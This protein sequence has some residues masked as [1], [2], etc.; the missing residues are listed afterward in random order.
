MY[1]AECWRKPGEREC[2]VALSWSKERQRA[3]MQRRGTEE[4]NPQGETRPEFF[5]RRRRALDVM[6]MRDWELPCDDCGH[7]G[8]LRATATQMRRWVAE[9]RLSC[10][11]KP[12]ARS[13]S[14]ASKPT[15]RP[16]ALCCSRTCATGSLY[17]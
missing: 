13:L 12:I 6:Q 3:N 17:R 1:G 10:E 4:A 11:R 14:I 15:N 2:D 8:K 16:R 7:I 9:E 5:K